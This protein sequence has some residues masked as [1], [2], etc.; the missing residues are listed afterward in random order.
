MAARPCIV[1][2]AARVH[3]WGLQVNGKAGAL[4]EDIKVARNKATLTITSNVDM[5]KRYLK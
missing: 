1:P 4:G 3:A 2:H 5:S